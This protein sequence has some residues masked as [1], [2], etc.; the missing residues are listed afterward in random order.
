MNR[1]PSKRRAFRDIIRGREQCA[2]KPI[3]GSSQLL[4]LGDFPN[5]RPS[6]GRPVQPP[7][8]LPN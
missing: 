8:I 7:P 5:R 3:Q 2:L 4:E 6:L 1:V